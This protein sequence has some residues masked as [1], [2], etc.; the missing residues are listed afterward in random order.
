M[1]AWMLSLT[2][3]GLAA[4]AGYLPRPEGSSR[5]TAVPMA[6][7]FAGVALAVA[8][9]LDAPAG[10]ARRA[11]PFAALDASASWLRGGETAR[12]NAARDSA[13]SAGADSIAMFGDSV[14]VGE[15]PAQPL[16]AGSRAQPVVERA[17]ASGRP[18][19]VV[20]DGELSDPEALRALPAGSRV[21]VA[22]PAQVRDAAVVQLEAPHAVVQGDT[23]DVRVDI[24]AGVRGAAAG[25]VTLLLGDATVGDAPFDSLPSWGERSVSLRA[26]ATVAAGPAVLRAVLRSAQDGEGRND[27]LAVA[28]DVAAQASAVFVS[29]S[30]D[31]DV[32]W[33]VAT[34]RGAVSLPTRA[35]YRVAPGQWRVEGS[36]APIAEGEVQK[37]LREAPLAVIHGDTA[38]FGAPLA[39]TRGALALL[40]P[41]R[42]RTGEWYASGTP[43]SPMVAALAGARWDSLPP[44][45]VALANAKGDWVA[46]EAQRSASDAKHP[47]VVGRS[48]PR[49]TVVVTASGFARWRVRAG[50]PADAFG[51]LWGAIFDWLAAE[52]PDVRAALPAGGVLREGDA[53]AWRRGGARDSVVRVVMQARA[54][55]AKSD[56]IVLRFPRGTTEAQSPALAVGVYDVRAPGG[57]S[58]LVV[59][60][61]LEWLPRRPTVQSGAVGGG[62]A[63]GD[64]PALRQYAWP[65]VVAVVLLCAEWFLRRRAGLR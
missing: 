16:D 37:V 14:R 1:I 52:R 62:A 31:A 6:L 3:G 19:I 28:I 59:N 20:T 25:R 5:D 29:T 61:G 27:T 60:R 40:A 35:Y 9:A 44:L 36:L 54:A 8:L 56:T 38:M 57:A 30:P 13:R 43:P 47:V 4:V 23:M 49:R 12:W 33:L 42:E 39:A 41:P 53:V 18:L 65:F 50:A 7:R 55:K 17:L 46:L 48:E 64:V 51:A 24:A 2:A 11:A 63:L 45:D 58:L 10:L 32:R 34:L 21:I 22:P 26:R 15:P